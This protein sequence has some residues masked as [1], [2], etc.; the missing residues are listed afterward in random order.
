MVYIIFDPGHYITGTAKMKDIWLPQS[1][2]MENGLKK[3]F[4][5]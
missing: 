3:F 1:N 5:S 2:F 4:Y